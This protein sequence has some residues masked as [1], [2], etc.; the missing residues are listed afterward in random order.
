MN[1]KITCRELRDN[2]GE[3]KFLICTLVTHLC[4]VS[5]YMDANERNE[6]KR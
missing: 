4:T 3:E 2:R 5:R 6:L 1:R